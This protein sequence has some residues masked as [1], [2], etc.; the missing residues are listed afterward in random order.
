VETIN[1]DEMRI[2]AKY[3]AILAT[4]SE[5]ETISPIQSE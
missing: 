3:N 4:S 1:T 2:T 5:M